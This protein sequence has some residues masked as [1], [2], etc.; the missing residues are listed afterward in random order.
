M[1]VSHS[2]KEEEVKLA[3]ELRLSLQRNVKRVTTWPSTTLTH[4][5]HGES[6]CLGSCPK[7]GIANGVVLAREAIMV[8]RELPV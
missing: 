1:G 6:R 2:L 3:L 4:V 5:F 8:N 7:E